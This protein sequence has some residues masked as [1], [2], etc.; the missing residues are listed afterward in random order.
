MECRNISL[1][2]ISRGF[3]AGRVVGAAI[4]CRYVVLECSVNE[5]SDSV[6]LI[7]RDIINTFDFPTVCRQHFRSF[8][9]ALALIREEAA[10]AR[11]IFCAKH[12]YNNKKQTKL[13][14]IIINLLMD[15][16]FIEVWQDVLLHN[17]IEKRREMTNKKNEVAFCNHNN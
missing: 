16:L 12:T 15:F 1:C 3:E 11:T 4:N 2:V 10:V 13:L 9:R 17:L 14:R 6:F 7:F 8:R 5:I